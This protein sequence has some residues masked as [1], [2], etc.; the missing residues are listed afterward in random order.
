[1]HVETLAFDLKVRMVVDG[2]A[3]ATILSKRVFDQL[4]DSEKEKLE[5][6][7]LTVGLAND[8]DMV[9]YGVLPLDFAIGGKAITHPMIVGDITNDALLGADFLEEYKCVVDHGM[10]SI[11]LQNVEIPLNDNQENPSSCRVIVRNC[12]TVP[13]FTEII[14]TATLSN[15]KNNKGFGIVEPTDLF[16]QKR[17][18]LLA[19]VVVFNNKMSVPLRL[20]NPSSESIVIHP[21]THVGLY[22]SI[23]ALTRLPGEKQ[24]DIRVCTAS[25]NETTKSN[26]ATC[27]E[28]LRK[29]M[30]EGSTELSKEQKI[31][32]EEL[33][34]EYS[35]VF[36]KENAPLGHTDLVKHTIDTGDTPPIRQRARRLPLASKEIADQEIDKMLATGI[37]EPSFSPWSSPIVL[38]K[39]KDGSTRFCV[40]YRKLNMAT[41]K[42]AY[43]LPRID[44]TIDALSG[45][46]FFTT[47]D[48]DSSYWQVEMDEKDKDKTA[49]AT[50]RGLFNFNVM[51]FGLCNAPSTFERLMERVLSGLHW[52]ICLVYLDDVI[53]YSKSFSEHVSRLKTVFQRFRD[54][55]LKLKPKKCH[56][57]Q[58]QVLYLGHIVSD[59]GVATDPAK[60]EKVKEWPQPIN[61]HQVRSFMGLASYYRKFCKD[62]AKVAKPLHKLT[63]KDQPFLWTDEC[64][65]AFECL[66]HKLVTAPILSYPQA[67]GLFILD[68][69]ASNSGIGS[70][71]SQ[72]Q[73]GEEKVIAY[74]SR[75]LASTEKNYCTTR[76]E[77]LSVVKFVKHFK[78]YLYGRKFLIRTDHASL[79]WL[80]NFK[81]PEGQM[82]RWL[83]S[84][85]VYD[86]DIVHR[87]GVAHGSADALSRYPCK[88]CKKYTPSSGAP[89]EL[90]QNVVV[91]SVS[92]GEDVF[93]PPLE[94]TE[95][96]SSN[97]AHVI[98]PKNVQQAQKS[99]PVVG[100]IMSYLEISKE[101]PKWEIISCEGPWFKTLWGSWALLEM[102]NG[103]LFRRME[104]DDGKSSSFRLVV[105]K[106]LQDVVLKQLHDSPTG[107]HLGVAKVLERCK[108]RYHWYRM[109]DTVQEWCRNCL[110]CALTKTGKKKSKAP[111]KQYVVGLPLERIAM[112][113][114]GPFPLTAGGNKYILVLSDYFTK[115]TEAYAL[116]NMEAETCARKLVDEF[117]CRFGC[118][119]ELHTD[120]GRQFEG[121]L[122]QETCK[123]LGIEKTRTTA[124]HPQSDGQ[125][126]RFNRTLESMLR[127]YVADNQNEWDLYLQVLMMAYRSSPH[128]STKVSPNEMIFGKEIRLPIDLVMG[129]C[130]QQAEEFS[131][132]VVHLR[133]QFED[134][135]EKARDHLQ[136]AAKRQKKNYD[137]N[138]HH[139]HYHIGD[140]VL[141]AN[142]AK[143][144][145]VCYK[146]Q[147]RW[148]G[149]FLVTQVISS[150]LLRIQEGP[151]SKPQLVHTN[152][153]Q[154]FKGDL[155]KSWFLKKHPEEPM[156]D[157]T[158]GEEN[159]EEQNHEEQNHEEQSHEEQSHKEQNLGIIPVPEQNV[160]NTGLDV[161][162]DFQLELELSDKEGEKD[163][164]ENEIQ[165]TENSKVE[166]VTGASTP[167]GQNEAD[168]SQTK[169]AQTNHRPRRN[170]K[171]PDRLGQWDYSQIV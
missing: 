153:L 132:Y 111:L 21:E 126:E 157:D 145:R 75:S 17:G 136:T 27:P 62:F 23:D 55:S 141:L 22:K 19:P 104:S 56:L 170:R 43:P 127:A 60:I 91:Q 87:P 138:L 118:P 49:F 97:W 93:E 167:T 98:D 115:W 3:S 83:H 168:G 150:V 156:N 85:A 124:Y 120:Q 163:G 42:D 66:R 144:V 1:M 114:V 18:L 67:S 69:D 81:E 121:K 65:A 133:D 100:R 57:F 158:T 76:K 61:V 159:H 35:D 6:T 45:S 139:L 32:L 131:Q 171:A 130:K 151:R 112:D 154:R 4:P 96:E 166:L 41:R 99:D 103:I 70:V 125:V 92:L 13:P 79:R 9:V 59:K 12:V 31:Q 10:G 149:P 117:I 135:H 110:V 71:L 140:A 72:V 58:K 86:F 29:V 147:R 63:E 107:G 48:M 11:H 68:T 113:L 33:L 119:V 34:S 30:E 24:A 164:I 102:H 37:I 106:E 44:D 152:R 169:Q 54:A 25:T 134:A 165:S 94:T 74:A 47:L 108:S 16:V 84:L 123:L 101:A 161:D 14:V 146:T 143:K 116:P 155:D 160:G 73:D 78:P 40:D 64:Q 2:G 53:V 38:V 26:A 15:V 162:S 137:K 105:P 148:K 95:M 7:D 88:V 129:Q 50:H 90:N 51:S 109:K 80:M 77:L 89:Q 128:E 46:V 122:F 82:A 52:E 36:A 8:A 142:T 20:L 5:P 39:K 28:H